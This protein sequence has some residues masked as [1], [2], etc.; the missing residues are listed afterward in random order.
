M[1]RLG[2]YSGNFNIGGSGRNINPTDPYYSNKIVHIVPGSFTSTTT[3]TNL[4]AID[5]GPNSATIVS[6]SSFSQTSL[7]P[8]GSRWSGFFGITGSYISGSDA[9]FNISGA[10]ATWNFECWVYPIAPTASVATSFYF[11]CIGSGSAYGNL[12]GLQW[13]SGNNKFQFSQGDGLTTNPVFF[14]TTNTYPGGK[15]YHVAVSCTSSGVRRLYVDGVLDGTQTYTFGL[16]GATT[17]VINGNNDG[18]G[19]GYVGGTFYISNVR[20]VSGTTLYTTSTS[21]TVPSS[22]LSV[23]TQ[24]QLLTCQDNIFK[25]NSIYSR[26]ITKGGLNSGTVPFNKFSSKSGSRISDF[27]GSGYFDGTSSSLQFVNSSYLDLSGTSW[28]IE[29]WIRPS[30]N[31][32]TNRTIFTKRSSA[33]SV[34]SY[35]GFLK[36]TTGVISYFN[37]TEYNS[38]VTLQA[39]AWSH[40]AWVYDGANLIIYVNGVNIYSV[41]TNIIDIDQTFTIGASRGYSE[42]YAG[43]I[44]NF[45]MVRGVVVYTGNFTPPFK[46][47]KQ[48]GTDSADSYKS[49]TNVNTT[50]PSS[51]TSLFLEFANSAFNDQAGLRYFNTVGAAGKKNSITKWGNGSLYIPVGGATASI[52]SQDSIPD[53]SI[54]TFPAAF[55]IECWVYLTNSG[56]HV[57]IG[58]SRG[59]ALTVTTYGFGIFNNSG[60]N[61]S[62]GVIKGLCLLLSPINNYGGNM[63]YSGQ[64]PTLNQWTHVA[65][66]RTASN[67]IMFFMDGVKGTTSNDNSNAQPSSV[68]SQAPNILGSMNM[69]L[70]FGDFNGFTS[71]TNAIQLASGFNG[72]IEDFAIYNGVAKYTASFT[73][74]G[75]PIITK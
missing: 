17:W 56:R 65:V 75:R 46:P 55:T 62:S 2:G 71:G 32:T 3:A 15:W 70:Y 30:R 44:S 16:V 7:S 60:A 33:S 41:A 53:N 26:T 5:T 58:D 64:Y 23:T 6:T 48:S 25:D 57:I 20:F 51:N 22:P 24:T 42:F 68:F 72:Y 54:I 47:L 73:K 18:S 38:T 36:A 12:F 9:A 63:L 10:G 66:T 67:E 14:T 28:T 19:L 13:D 59:T 49:K 43:H 69:T 45:R 50:F 74:P 27:S 31:Y 34:T 29:C 1:P 52:N 8:Y 21:F 35:A 37:G 39:G 61:G 11:F 4:A 40:C